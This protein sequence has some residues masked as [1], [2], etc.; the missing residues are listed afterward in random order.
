MNVLYI[1]GGEGKR[2][3][4]EIIAMDLIA[5]GK[6]NDIEYTVITARKGV[7][8]EA[9]EKYGVTNYVIPFTFYVYKA[10]HNHFLNVIKKNLWKFRAD[11]LTNRAVK[12]IERIVDLK[13]ID[14]IHTNLSR[15]LLGGILA[16]KHN[17]P[18]IWH[19][20]E[21]YNAHYQLTFLKDKQLEWMIKRAN[22]FAAISDTVAADWISSGV[23]KEKVKTVYNGVNLKKIEKKENEFENGILKIVMVGHLCPAKGQD[24]VIK[25]LSKLSENSIKK[26]SFDCYGEGTDNYKS[27]LCELAEKNGVAFSLKGYCSEIEKKLKEYDI[28]VNCS[29]GEGFG[30]STVEYMA[31]GLCTLVSNTGANEEIIQNKVNGYVFDYKNENDFAEIIEHLLENRQEMTDVAQTASKDAFERFSLERMQ[32]DIADLYKRM[33]YRRRYSSEKN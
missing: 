26:V 30:L 18:H 28:G 5:S 17:I 20:Q 19:L 23:P 27:Y 21:L 6:R 4:S 25:K 15:D 7:V 12:E 14:V 16:E 9:C 10:M 22:V 33:N 32:N 1:V 31:A 3:G 13:S 8:N 11:F 24:A 2:Y 29:R